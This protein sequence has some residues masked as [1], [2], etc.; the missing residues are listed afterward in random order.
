MNQVKLNIES[1]E[2]AMLYRARVSLS[3]LLNN[4]RKLPVHGVNLDMLK[5]ARAHARE[6]LGIAMFLLT[7]KEYTYTTSTMWTKALYPEFN[8][9]GDMKSSSIED[10]LTHEEPCIRS[11]PTSSATKL[12]QGIATRHNKHS[13]K[14]LASEIDLDL[15]D[16]LTLLVRET[17]TYIH[18]LHK[19]IRTHIAD[20]KDI[21]NTEEALQQAFQS[22][23]IVYHILIN[24]RDDYAGPRTTP[25]PEPNTEPTLKL[26]KEAAIQRMIFHPLGDADYLPGCEPG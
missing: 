16:E 21:T 3:R 17:Y 5:V 11:N 9:P 23:K 10:K 20:H 2:A 22:L 12:R 7:Q 26:G 1:L 6:N 13:Q 14:K 15:M 4:T 18:G 8:I 19:R 24:A 25:W